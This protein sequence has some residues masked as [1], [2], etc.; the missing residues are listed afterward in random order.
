ML[1]KIIFTVIIFSS[2][3]VFSAP[4]KDARRFNKTY[5]I[6]KEITNIAAEERRARVEMLIRLAAVNVMLRKQEDLLTTLTFPR[7]NQ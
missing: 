1:N 2:V 3:A 5:E 4:N 7:S 6:L